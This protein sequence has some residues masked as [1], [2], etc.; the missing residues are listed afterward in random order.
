[1]I[2]KKFKVKAATARRRQPAPDG[3][4]RVPGIFAND[5]DA[6]FHFIAR[7]NLTPLRSS[8]GFV[9]SNPSGPSTPCGD[10]INSALLHDQTIDRLV[11][12]MARFQIKS[13]AVE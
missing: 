11:F 4:A 12:F 5:Q 13:I 2:F 10:G 1:V 7:G 9:A 6:R 3:L 8:C